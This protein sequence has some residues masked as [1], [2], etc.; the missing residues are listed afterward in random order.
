MVQTS[1]AVETQSTTVTITASTVV[2]TAAGFRPLA[3]TTARPQQ[4]RWDEF[5]DVVKRVARK[6]T[7]KG[8]RNEPA[9]PESVSCTITKTLQPFKKNIIPGRVVTK[10]AI[11]PIRFITTVKTRVS[12]STRLPATV[13]SIATELTTI[14]ATETE[15]SMST[16]R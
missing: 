16:V 11:K 4:R 1:T 13:T 5:N 6:Q 3:D 15:S 8:L 12:T 7:S 2:P 14:T 10:T 9:Y